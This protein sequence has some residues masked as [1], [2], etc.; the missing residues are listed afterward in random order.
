M[1]ESGTIMHWTGSWNQASSPTTFSLFYV[2]GTGGRAW[3]AGQLGTLLQ[4][5]SGNWSRVANPAEQTQDGFAALWAS[6]PA[7]IWVVGSRGTILHYDGATMP[8]LV[9]PAPTTM[10]LGGIWGASASNVY[11]GAYASPGGQMGTVVHYNGSAWSALS[12]L[13]TDLA[14]GR[15]AGTGSNDVWVL[16]NK[17]LT[18]DSRGLPLD[19]L[20]RAL[21]YDGRVWSTVVPQPAESQSSYTSIFV[22][23]TNDVWLLGQS[24][25]NHIGTILH[26]DGAAWSGNVSP[27]TTTLHGIYGSGPRDIW[28]VGEQGTVLHFDGSAWSQPAFITSGSLFGVW[29]P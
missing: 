21:H 17:T 13:P 26:W 9:T 1:G 25:A 3:A 14:C 24:G 5:S 8:T 27:T 19:L 15:A 29:V 6:S 4:Y 20:G 11:V 28:A 23:G 12:G 2:W 16:A 18:T 10:H 22:S 7:D